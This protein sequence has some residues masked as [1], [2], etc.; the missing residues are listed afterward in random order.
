MHKLVQHCSVET[1]WNRETKSRVRNANVMIKPCWGP[2]LP[3][4]SSPH[5]LTVSSV[6]MSPCSLI[7]QLL[8][9]PGMQ[10]VLTSSQRQKKN[11]VLRHLFSTHPSPTHSSWQNPLHIQD[12]AVFLFPSFVTKLS[13]M[14][15]VWALAQ[16]GSRRQITKLKLRW[17]Q[18]K[19]YS[20]AKE[21]RNRR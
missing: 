19:L 4:G 14:V 17:T 21:W 6:D 12:P 13:C 11:Q 15:P 3:F 20:W 8:L 5:S 10:W 1:E 2:F 18:H 9:V 16:L 7:S